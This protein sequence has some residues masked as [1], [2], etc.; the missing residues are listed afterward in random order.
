AWFPP[1][2]DRAGMWGVMGRAKPGVT[3][4]A[5]ATDLDDIAHRFAQEHPSSD[6]T[7]ATFVIATRSL[8]DSVL[9]SFR[10]TLYGLI[11]AVVL[12]LAIACT[13]VANLL[14]ARATAREREIAVRS[15]L[16]ATA[17]RLV[18]QLFVEGFILAA[19]ASAIGCAV[20][21]GG[22]RL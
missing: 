7:P 9:G 4:A 21:Y 22:L 15:A 20:A 12:L 13:N 11:V 17:G 1:R 5:A 14:L 19:A 6:M 10:N 18:R 16:G 8:L 3:L 2:I